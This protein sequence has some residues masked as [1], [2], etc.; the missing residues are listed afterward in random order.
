MEEKRIKKIYFILFIFSLLFVLNSCDNTLTVKFETNCDIKCND[1]KLNV[2]D[3]VPLYVDLERV[4]YTFDGWYY[5]DKKWNSAKDTLQESITLD[6]HW[7][8][9]EYQINLDANSEIE[10]DN[11]ILKVQYDSPYDLPI[12][13]R[14]GYDFLGWYQNDEKIESGIYQIPSD[15]S[16]TAKWKIKTF[17]VS[18]KYYNKNEFETQEVVYGTKLTE[19][20]V[21]E[22]IGY[23]YKGWYVNDLKWDFEDDVV[24]NNMII[25]EKWQ[26]LF[27]FKKTNDELSIARFLIDDLT[28]LEVPSMIDGCV[29]TEIQSVAFKHKNKLESI[30]LPDTIKTIKEGA[31][32]ECSS[33]K[34]I[35]L[36]KDLKTI[37]SW[38][39]DGCTSL[40][41]IDIPEGVEVIEQYA[42]NMCE[43][44]TNINLPNTLLKIENN[45]FD[46][47]KNLKE[48][49]LPN[50]LETLNEMAL[51]RT[52]FDNLIIPASVVNIGAKAIGLNNKD[53]IIYCER[54][55][56]PEGW[57]ENWCAFNRTVV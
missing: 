4:G 13:E 24:T 47:C 49:V 39:F 7:L 54:E 25:N 5:G 36:P 50:K 32:I 38:L 23:I 9:I 40:T 35:K 42:F 1:L 17:V 33:L 52:Y 46:G 57:V 28:E 11:N 21:Q 31:F 27:E 14:E 18:Y 2:G 45:V 12:L 37:S 48:I 30:I 56:K 26:P 19:P 34:S 15:L 53:A 29:V 43:N 16:L 20:L 44:L 55:E 22:R 41:S 3:K 51:Y 8:P 6:A 10:L